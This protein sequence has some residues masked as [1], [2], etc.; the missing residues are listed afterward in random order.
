MGPA[1]AV[2][3]VISLTGLAVR[4]C[5][6]SQVPEPSSSYRNCCQLPVA[7]RVQHCPNVSVLS[8]ECPV[9]SVPRAMSLSRSR[10]SYQYSSSYSAEAAAA[11]KSFR[12]TRL[13]ARL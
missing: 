11:I 7:S 5:S 9:L 3:A 12:H 1:A 4:V 13:E 8:V 6:R 10:P 2:T